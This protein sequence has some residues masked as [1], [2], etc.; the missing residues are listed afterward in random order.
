MGQQLQPISSS[1]DS[2][3]HTEHASR[4]QKATVTPREL[5]HPASLEITRDRT[6]P[7]DLPSV[8]PG[9]NNKLRG[10]QEEDDSEGST[11]HL[12]KLIG[13]DSFSGKEV[14][15]SE[16]ERITDLERQLSETLAERD[17]HIAQAAQ[18]TDQL[19]QKTVLLDQAEANAL[20][21][22]KRAGLELRELQ[23]KLGES[24]MS[25]DHALEQAR[26]AQKKA[27]CAAEANEQ[28]QR[29][30]M[31]MRAE[32]EASKSELAA[33][34]S[35]LADTENDCAK[36]KAG[37][38][39]YRT[40]VETNLVN[41]DEDQVVNRLMERMQAMEAEM[42][43]MASGRWNDKNFEMRECRNEG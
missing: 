18:L 3:V 22:K 8:L 9:I 28:S 1:S 39:T 43:I 36:S 13:P 40:Q 32:L 38:V 23:A 11:E 6:S 21:E 30:L 12:A 33:L 29:E 20:E 10:V 27:S 25:R 2:D 14:A 31:E 17:R 15:R 24:V 5:D 26:S 35:R 4:F 19:A 7:N 37:A 16:Q 34:R 41:T 42:A